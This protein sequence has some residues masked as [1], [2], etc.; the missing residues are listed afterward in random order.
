MDERNPMKIQYLIHAAEQSRYNAKHW[1][2]YL[3]KQIKGET[4]L[5][6]PAEVESIIESGE[7]TM[8]QTISLKRAMTPGTPTYHYV[9]A[10]NQRAETPMIDQ[11][12]RKYNHARE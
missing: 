10:L 3:R 2:R 1:L 9:S 12:L 6:T 11:I 8:Y 7:L 4:V 5:L